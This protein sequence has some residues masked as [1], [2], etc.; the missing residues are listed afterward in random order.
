MRIDIIVPVY[1]DMWNEGILEIAQAYKPSDFEIHIHN[2]KKGIPSIECEYDAAIA[3]SPT[4]LMTESIEKEGSDAIIIYCFNDPALATCKEKLSIPVVGLRE[5][6]ILQASLIG[7][8][9]GIITSVRNSIPSFE[10]SLGN[11]VKKVIALDL[12]VL[13]FLDYEKVE[14]IF[15]KKVELLHNDGCDVIV[16]GCGS[17][18]GINIHKIRDDFCIPIVVPLTA[19]LSVA[20]YMVRNRLVQ[21]KKSFPYPPFKSVK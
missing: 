2:V 13:E 1:V 17:I 19:S 18:L 20:E 15:E 9:I 21:S 3:S 7:S 6:S 4:L 16:L 14:K 5:S 8:H 11:K 12:P 10:K